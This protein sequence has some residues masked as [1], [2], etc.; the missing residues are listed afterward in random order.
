MVQTNTYIVI[1]DNKGEEILV[2]CYHHLLFYFFLFYSC[3]CLYMHWETVIHYFQI[4]DGEKISVDES[5]IKNK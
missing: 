2:V 4:Y 1:R 3:L 5:V